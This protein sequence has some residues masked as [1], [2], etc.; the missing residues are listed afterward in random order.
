MYL[1]LALQLFYAPFGGS[2]GSTLSAT[3][4][5]TQV[6]LFT[7]Y[8]QSALG[9]LL[10]GLQKTISQG[11]PLVGGVGRL[12][13]LHA[14]VVALISEYG[15][16]EMAIEQVFVN[17]NLQT[18]TSVGRA[19]GVILLA[20]AQAGI[21]AFEYT[22]SAVKLAVCGVGDAAKAQV[23]TVVAMRLGLDAAPKPVDASDAVAVA[24]CHMQSSSL[25]RAV[26]AAG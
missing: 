1:I 9:G 13:E 26:E 25:R 2:D 6:T 17:R 8:T 16:V 22:P 19:S 24:L 12:A 4:L 5:N 10:A 20:A 14:D 11:P 23:A 3:E 21:P 18:A 7:L 15:P